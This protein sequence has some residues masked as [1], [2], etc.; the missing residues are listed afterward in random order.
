VFIDGI[1][2]MASAEAW[3]LA[4]R[5]YYRRQDAYLG[6]VRSD[7]VDDQRYVVPV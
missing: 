4:K 6:I 2:F 7:T 3:K 1:I 5:V